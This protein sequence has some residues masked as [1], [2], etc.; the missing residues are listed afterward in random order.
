MGST[1]ISLLVFLF[2][3]Q[4]ALF[5]DCL[6]DE[7]RMEFLQT[8]GPECSGPLIL[9]QNDEDILPSQLAAVSLWYNLNANNN[10]VSACVTRCVGR[11]LY[12]VIFCRFVP[13]I[14]SV[15]PWNSFRARKNVVMMNKIK[16]SCPFWRTYCAGSKTASITHNQ[17]A[18]FKIL[19]DLF[20]SLM[21]VLPGGILVIMTHAHTKT[22]LSL[23]QR[24]KMH[25]DVATML[26]M[27][28]SK[29]I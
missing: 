2:A 9:L 14:A 4:I 15:K 13:K 10:Y 6:T 5:Q 21:H 12:Y 18:I 19:M 8:V 22:V 1:F 7:G 3:A 24:L 26:S 16:G 20:L 28:M 11:I 25:M 17:A 23:W 29:L 27:E